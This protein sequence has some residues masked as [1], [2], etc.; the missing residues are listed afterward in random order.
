[1]ASGSVDRMALPRPLP[2]DRVQKGFI[3]A[4]ICTQEQAG[5]LRRCRLDMPA[6]RGGGV[7]LRDR[8]R[9]DAA[10]Y[11]QPGEQIQ[12]VFY[13]K[14]PSMPYNDRAVVATDRRFLLVKLNFFG[15]GTGL[16]GDAPRA[17]RLGPCSGFMYPIEA[18]GTPL[19]VSF[20]FFKD[21]AEAGRAAGFQ[22]SLDALTESRKHDNPDQ[23]SRR[24]QARVA[25]WPA[26]NDVGPRASGVG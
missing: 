26:A 19:A 10:R 9:Q 2:D 22:T 21:V 24:Q 5:R 8:L 11:L 13:A 18:F 3:D 6:W 15:R 7:A 12:A 4:S 1:M 14:R 20:R 25:A 16:A 17:V 23:A